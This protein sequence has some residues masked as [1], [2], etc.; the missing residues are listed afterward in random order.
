MIRYLLMTMLVIS[1]AGCAGISIHHT[2][3]V[4][5]QNPVPLSSSTFFFSED[6]GAN[7]WA[8]EAV[9][10]STEALTKKEFI[11]AW[12]EPQEKQI[13][14]KGETWIYSE[15]NR[16]CGLVVYVIVP[17]P[18]MLPICETY[19]KVYFEHGVAVSSDSHRYVGYAFVLTITGPGLASP[20]G[21][22]DRHPMV[23]AGSAGYSNACSKEHLK[24]LKHK[25]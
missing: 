25:E 8:C 22:H 21:V 23:G 13:T 2:E 17:I 11:S 12:G 4:S 18:L 24:P 3:T 6:K 10:G 14:S 19:D 9:Y 20:G 16:W 15:S 7:R 5:V 1:T